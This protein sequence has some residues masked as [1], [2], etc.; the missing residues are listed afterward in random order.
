TLSTP[1]FEDNYVPHKCLEP[2]V[3][4]KSGLHGEW[5]LW[6]EPLQLFLNFASSLEDDII[7]QHAR[8]CFGPKD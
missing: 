1:L 4:A 7:N 8:A 6:L 3:S 5:L 2:R